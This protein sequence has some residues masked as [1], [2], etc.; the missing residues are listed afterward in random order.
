VY[1]RLCT[2]RRLL[3]RL[4]VLL[5]VCAGGGCAAVSN[6]T[7]D[8]IPVRRL[9]PEVF[10]E[11][12]ENLKPIAVTALRQSPAKVYLLAP[13]DVLGVYIEGVLGERTVPP[14]VRIPE[15]GNVPPALGFP[16]PVREDG[17]VPLPL[18]KPVKVEGL[19]LAE[20]Q[21]KIVEEYTTKGDILKKDRE[22][23]IVTLIQP[24]KY[25][26]L[27]L[28]EDAGGTTF[29]T[30]G[31]F[32]AALT[33]GGGSF[34]QETRRA[35]G[36][37]LELP[38]YENDVLN[39]LT[40]SGGLPGLEAEDE[41]IVERGAYKAATGQQPGVDGCLTRPA[42]QMITQAAGQGT[43]TL[44]IP[45]R[46]RP[47]QPLG[48]RPQDI[49]LNTGDVVIVRARRNEFFYTGGL[50]PTRAFPVPRDRDLDV[51]QAVA[52]VGG[53]LINGGTNANNLSGNL[54]QSGIGFPS[55]SQLAVVRQTK[56][57]GQI[58]ILVNLNR[59]LRDPRERILVQE[60]DFLILQQSVDEGLA[61]WFTTNFRFNWTAFLVRQRDFIFTNN[62][63]LP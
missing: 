61:Q 43:E 20:A 9:P 15:Q 4:G 26:V 32:G 58:T 8:G 39:A 34:F 3:L 49:I 13:G 14:P 1:T 5:V 10:G 29:G 23:I 42:E 7:V 38:A 18:L 33:G 46:L 12:R 53:P 27:V 36:F 22:R 41:V 50:L 28:R 47:G 63:T 2:C 56:D 17:T 19:S 62:T 11:S 16:L 52:L 25:H 59:A 60:G 24:R 54:V 30:Q 21:T 31:G 40:R 35:T 44:R 48:L 45:L 6:P 57:C 51:L 37:A 55:P